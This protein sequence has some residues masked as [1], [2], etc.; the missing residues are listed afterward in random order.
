MII[1]S[2]LK[3]NKQTIPDSKKVK[4]TRK[5]PLWLPTKKRIA[6]LKHHPNLKQATSSFTRITLA[7]C[8][9]L[10]VADCNWANRVSVN[11]SGSQGNN[12]SFSGVTSNDGRYVAFESA[13]SNLVANDTNGETD[14]FLHD[15][16]TGI[17]IRIRVAFDGGTGLPL[18]TNTLQTR[19]DGSG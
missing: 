11:S 5:T 14:I 17:T 1:R 8:L 16:V 15:T 13:A 12:G 10:A 3:N 6:R 19:G 2:I 9:V 4:N 7:V 18:F